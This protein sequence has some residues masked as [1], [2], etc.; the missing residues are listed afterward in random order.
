MNDQPKYGPTGWY[1]QPFSGQGPFGPWRT[2]VHVTEDGRPILTDS[3]V[4]YLSTS[5]AE[6]KGLYGHDA[7][8]AQREGAARRQARRFVKLRAQWASPHEVA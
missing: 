8:P 1:T 7:T 5:P 3:E 2:M 6:V 4:R